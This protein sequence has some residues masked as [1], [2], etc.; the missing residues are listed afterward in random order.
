M[1]NRI[2]A[3]SLLLSL[4]L[5][6]CGGLQAGLEPATTSPTNTAVA[7]AP[8]TT[9][10]NPATSALPAV[11]ATAAPSDSQTFYDSTVGFQLE[12][13]AGWIIERQAASPP[14]VTVDTLAYIYSEVRPPVRGKNQEGPAHGLKMDLIIRNGQGT[15]T[16]DQ[17]VDDFKAGITHAN[18]QVTSE[19]RRTLASGVPVAELHTGVGNEAVVVLALFLGCA[20]FDPGLEHA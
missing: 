1:T 17:I 14:P 5:A 13:P 9:T 8:A 16:L 11:T 2:C 6:G 4:A 10:A 7:A 18:E 20:G 15:M 19:Q 12:L 3:L